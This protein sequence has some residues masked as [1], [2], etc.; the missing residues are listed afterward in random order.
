[1]AAISFILAVLA[2]ATCVALG[3]IVLEEPN[4]LP[5]LNL[6]IGFMLVSV[7][8]GIWSRA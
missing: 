5:Q 3:A 8:Y 6:I 1:M 7:G 2:G 4:D